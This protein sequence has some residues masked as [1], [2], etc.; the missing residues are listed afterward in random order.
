MAGGPQT[1]RMIWKQKTYPET[2]GA[3]QAMGDS[4]SESQG[5][6]KSWQI[7]SRSQ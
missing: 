1:V 7:V 6:G 3:S 5:E 2:P 4:D